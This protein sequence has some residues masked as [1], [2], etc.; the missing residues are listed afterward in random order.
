MRELENQKTAMLDKLNY[1]DE[2]KLENI[3][4][5][6]EK[7]LYFKKDVYDLDLFKIAYKYSNNYSKAEEKI[8]EYIMNKNVVKSEKTELIEEI[9]VVVQF[10]INVANGMIYNFENLFLKTIYIYYCII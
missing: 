5:I 8:N 4:I 7:D 2:L 9:I 1:I 3:E 10:L 6:F